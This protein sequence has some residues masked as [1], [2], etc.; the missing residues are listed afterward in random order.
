MTET[1]KLAQLQA[2]VADS[3]LDGWLLYDFR[4]LNPFPA[5]ILGLGEAMLT[6]RWFLY[7][8]A[9]GAPTLICH[10]IE[11]GGWQ[12]LLP[13]PSIKRI[14]F[15]AHQELDAALHGDAARCA[16]RG[17]GVQPARRR[18]LREFR[19]RRDAGARARSA[20]AAWRSSP[21]PTCCN[22]SSCGMTKTGWRTCAPWMR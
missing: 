1:S 2:L 13:D 22:T 20:W 15:G 19:G 9:T 12:A 6:R 18:A 8:P 17:N 10:R 16:P 11:A 5:Q 4:G 7:V 3:G 21:A 14:V